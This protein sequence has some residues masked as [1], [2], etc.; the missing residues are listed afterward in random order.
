ML[1]KERNMGLGKIADFSDYTA[2]W[3]NLS[4]LVFS[5]VKSISKRLYE[6]LVP[7]KGENEKHEEKYLAGFC[8]SIQPK[9][10]SWGLFQLRVL[11]GFDLAFLDFAEIHKVLF[12]QAGRCRKFL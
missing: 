3:Y 11:L 2:I 5:C 4:T 8:G 9:G 1:L 7:R 10:V 12:C 6:P